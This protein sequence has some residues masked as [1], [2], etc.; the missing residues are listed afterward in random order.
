MLRIA[1]IDIETTGFNQ[2]KG[3]IL[4]VGLYDL[5]NSKTVNE[6][7]HTN[8]PEDETRDAIKVN[9]LTPEQIDLMRQSNPD[10][11]HLFINHLTVW[12]EIIDHYDIIVAHN[13]KFDIGWLKEKG[14]TFDK[15]IIMC[16]QAVMQKFKFKSRWWS[17]KDCLKEL[18][19]DYDPEQHHSAV[20]DANRCA[21]VFEVLCH[22][23]GLVIA[24]D[25]DNNIKIFK[26]KN[27]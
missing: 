2:K 27:E 9:K 14:L 22:E 5:N 21:A 17:L 3:D 8:L 20:Y 4:E 18:N 11:P 16:T 6:W 15:N 23:E 7:Y 10:C 13:A 25:L 26:K 12:Q 24:H 19:L 1:A